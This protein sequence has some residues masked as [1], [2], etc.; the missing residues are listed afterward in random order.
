MDEP[1]EALATG[2]DTYD[3]GMLFERIAASPAE[4]WQ[5]VAVIVTA[6]V[7]L[8]YV[9]DQI[10]KFLEKH[11]RGDIMDAWWFGLR[12]PSAFLV[13]IAGLYALAKIEQFGFNKG[14]PLG[15]VNLLKLSAAWVFTW[16]MFRFAR[17]LQLNI[18]TDRFHPARVDLG[19]ADSLRTLIRLFAVSCGIL[20]T[21]DTLGFNLSS[22]LAFGS[23]SGLVAGLAAKDLVANFAGSIMIRMDRP[24]VVGEWIRSPDQE[25]EGTVEEIGVRVTRIRTFDQRPLYVPNSTF[26]RISVETPSRML[27][28]RIKETI[29]VR[30]DDAAVVKPIIDDVRAMLA[31]HDAIDKNRI[32]MV[33][34]LSFGPSALEF[35]IYTFT[36]TTDW[37]T[38]HQI[39]EDVLLKVMDIIASHNAEVAFPTQTLKVEM[40]PSEQG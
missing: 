34:L 28:R 37:A 18:S 12:R 19:T 4:F 3:V 29:G 9:V 39:K 14:Y 36:R 5:K 13:I 26:T 35:F 11:P 32:L 21:L 15:V 2:I 24:F 30:Y 20:Y 31:E 33:N 22:L 25:I 23:V 40:E 7:V 8:L 1:S 17:R 16:V 6:T 38:Y 27:N 10:F